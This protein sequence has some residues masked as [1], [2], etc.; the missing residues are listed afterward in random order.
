MDK[1]YFQRMWGGTTRYLYLKELYVIYEI[2]LK[3]ITD[4]NI[5]TK[6]IRHLDEYLK[7]VLMTI[8]KYFLATSPKPRP[9]KEKW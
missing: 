3:C 6:I 4:Q 1:L 5:S 9:L 7:K 2:N 8:V